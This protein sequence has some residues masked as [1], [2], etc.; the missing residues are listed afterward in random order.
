M[1]NKLLS[2]AKGK[3]FVSCQG[4]DERTFHTSEDML[5]MANA[6][7]LGGCHG[8]RVNSPQ[9]VSLFKQKYPTYPIIGIY[10]V[11]HSLSEVYITPD[12]ESATALIQAGADII[13][14]DATFRKNHLA[15]YGWQT[16]QRIKQRY[17]QTVVMADCSTYEEAEKAS[18][19]GADI[20]STTLSGYTS[21]TLDLEPTPDYTM[22]KKCKQN[23]QAFVICEGRIWSREDAATA[24]SMG[25]DAIV[26]GTAITNPMLITKRY[27]DYLKEKKIW[28]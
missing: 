2:N 14:L 3:L 26:V 10:K 11:A 9:N 1:K 4:Y 18:Q 20:V 5:I 22:L 28:L 17:P 7:V 23:L 24:F 15:E 6:A 12:L 25:A 21:K 8:F 27:V 16:I 13:A 19:A